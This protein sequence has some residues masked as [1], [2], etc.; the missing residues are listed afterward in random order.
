[1]P[2]RSHGTATA[3]ANRCTGRL[4]DTDEVEPCRFFL[5][6]WPGFARRG[7]LRHYLHTAVE[8]EGSFERNRINDLAAEI[9]WHYNRVG[10]TLPSFFQDTFAHDPASFNPMR[11]LT[12]SVAHAD[13]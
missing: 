3:P 11:M 1:M 4:I 12:S 9:E 10:A 13:W 6:E 7:A 5:E 2:R 8:H